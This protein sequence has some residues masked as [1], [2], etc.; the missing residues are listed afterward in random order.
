MANL[1]TLL[2]GIMQLGGGVITFAASLMFS[3]G[4]GWSA[5]L[6]VAAGTSIAVG[7]STLQDM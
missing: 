5:G 1:W 7:I 3:P 6:G 4:I 2:L